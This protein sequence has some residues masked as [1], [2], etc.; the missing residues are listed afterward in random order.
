M[1]EVAAGILIEDGRVLACQR[2][3]D[4]SHPGKWEFPGGKRQPGESLAACLQRELRE[5]LGIEA[6]VGPELWRT[7]YYYRPHAPVDVFFFRITSYAGTVEN[8]AFADL[9]WV[10]REN[11][12]SLEFLDADRPLVRQLERGSRRG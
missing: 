4:G 9:R 8:R 6:T 3:F 1:V 11:L 12:S 10:E 7:R 5:E 2:R